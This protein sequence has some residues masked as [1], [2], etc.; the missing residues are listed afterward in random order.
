MSAFDDY[1]GAFE[2]VSM[3]R[4]D[5]ILELTLH[6]QGGSLVWGSRPHTEL[7]QFFGVVCCDPTAVCLQ[8]HTKTQISR[9][10]NQREQ[11]L[12]EKDF[13]AGK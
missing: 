7:G 3:R 4:E 6:S 1:A 8:L 11:V 12:S 10:F 13:A 9:G 5:G 2:H